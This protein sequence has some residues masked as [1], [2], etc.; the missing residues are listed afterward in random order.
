MLVLRRKPGQRIT[1]GDDIV[2]TVVEICGQQVRIGIDADKATPVH[3]EEVSKA[4]KMAQRTEKET[5][6]CRTNSMETPVISFNYHGV[7]LSVSD[8]PRTLAGWVAFSI[9]FDRN[10]QCCDKEAAMELLIHEAE[11]IINRVRQES[12]AAAREV[13]PEIKDE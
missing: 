3:R 10:V 7:D 8:F 2:V 12:D 6:P 11:Q 5:Q 13:Q 9:A 4:I 1:I